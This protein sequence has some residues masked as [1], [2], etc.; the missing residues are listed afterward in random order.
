MSVDDLAARACE[1]VQVLGRLDEACVKLLCALMREETRRFT[2]LCPPGGWDRDAV[3]GFVSEFFI[4]KVEKLTADLVTIGVTPQVVA[5]VMRRWV[6]NFLIDRARGTPLG[7]IRRKIEEDMLGQYPEF[8]RVP[9]GE[10]G[11]GRWYLA[12]QP[13][14]PYGGDFAPLI[15][16][17]Y[18][19]PGVKAVRWRRR[20]M[21]P[22]S[23][24]CARLCL[25]KN[26][27]P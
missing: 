15:S 16:A 3:D 5:K 17:A 13:S 19:V 20:P 21:P 14:Y 9:V 2:V 4:E 6:R 8:L 26:S 10:V 25:E 11:A 18:A 7:R 27:W 23:S 24:R 22:A 1:E 12:G